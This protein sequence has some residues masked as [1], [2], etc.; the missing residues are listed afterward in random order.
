LQINSTFNPGAGTLW[1]SHQPLLKARGTAIAT[2]TPPGSPQPFDRSL[3]VNLDWSGG[4]G[5]HGSN[6]PA[7]GESG[8]A[9]SSGSYVVDAA[10]EQMTV[11]G[12]GN[13][14]TLP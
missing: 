2:P 6:F 8:A 9:S 5:A 4:N 13:A 12:G 1:E 7:F 10:G 3:E 11:T 14:Y